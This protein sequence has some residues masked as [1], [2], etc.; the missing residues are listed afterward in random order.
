[1]LFETEAVQFRR[2]N[3]DSL[4]DF[5]HG[6]G[7][8]VERGGEGLDVFAFERSDEGLAKLLGQ[9]LGNALVFAPAGDEFFQTLGGIVMLEFTEKIDEM[10]DAAVGL[11]RALLQEVE[12]LFVVAEELPDREHK[13]LL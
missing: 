13:I 7:N 5:L 6:F 11:L 4:P 1:M 3:Q 8:L 12:E 10:V 2:E 9:L